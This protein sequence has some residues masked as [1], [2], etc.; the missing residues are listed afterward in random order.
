MGAPAAR[1]GD[2]VTATDQHIV[3]TSGASS[4]VPLPFSGTIQSDTVDTVLI[5]KR[6]AAVVDSVA[7]NVPPHVPPPGSSFVTPP[8]NQGTVA[9]G[10]STVSIDGRAAARVG[11][12]VR[13]CN[14]PVDL[15]VGRVTT[16]SSTV[17]IGG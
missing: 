12:P 10:S 3:V 13:T 14:D 8:S 7:K 5:D 17:T 4:T 6:P 11:D 1:Q 15:P 16:G 9:M 2:T